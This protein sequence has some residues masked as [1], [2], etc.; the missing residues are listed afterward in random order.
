[1]NR[2]DPD[3]ARFQIA[4][5]GGDTAFEQGL[6]RWNATDGRH[7][8]WSGFAVMNDLSLDV[9]TSALHGLS[10]RQ[11]AIADN[12]ANVQTPNYLARRVDFEG[13]LERAMADGD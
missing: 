9:L 8:P 7:G 4:T 1:M 11:R 6:A 12:I 3:G 10:E 5:L 2:S 13:N